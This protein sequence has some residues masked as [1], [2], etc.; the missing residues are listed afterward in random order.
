MTSERSGTPEE[1]QGSNM[2]PAMVSG[3][4]YRSTAKGTCNARVIMLGFLFSCNVVRISLL[5]GV[6]VEMRSEACIPG[7]PHEINQFVHSV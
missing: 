4:K 6:T 5:C 2:R 1:T 3:N 7:S